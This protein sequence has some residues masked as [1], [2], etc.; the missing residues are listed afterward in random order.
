LIPAK[1][2]L[3]ESQMDSTQITKLIE[4]LQ[5]YVLHAAYGRAMLQAHSLEL[6]LANLLIT[7]LVDQKMDEDRFMSEFARIKR[8]TMGKL[9]AEVIGKYEISDYWK[10]EFDNAL[11]FRNRLTHRI[12][13]DIISSHFTEDGKTK[14]ISEIGFLTQTCAK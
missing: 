4:S 13:E 8:L 3:D 6:S 12:C 1:T 5:A 9:I 2:I 7:N 11:Y 14:L 10:E